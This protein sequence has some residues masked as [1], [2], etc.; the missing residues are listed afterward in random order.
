MG[1]GVFSRDW[2][3]SILSMDTE[4]LIWMNSA[5]KEKAQAFISELDEEVNLLKNLSPPNIMY[6]RQAP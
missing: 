5:S 2:Q 6:Q 3:W 1:F 4:V